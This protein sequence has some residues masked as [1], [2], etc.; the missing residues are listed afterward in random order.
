MLGWI[1]MI[2]CPS[3]N[4]SVYI[5][6]TTKKYLSQRKAQ[7]VYDLTRYR[8]GKYSYCSSFDILQHPD[9]VVKKL[10]KVDV[11]S[12]QELRNIE[13]LVIRG[14]GDRAVNRHYKKI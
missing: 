6:S 11:E 9:A 13:R 10:C 12:V 2:E 1:Y 3:V 4:N 14:Y 7:H 8:A 5:G